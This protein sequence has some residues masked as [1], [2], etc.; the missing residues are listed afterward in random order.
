MYFTS[1]RSNGSVREKSRLTNGLP[2]YSAAVQEKLHRHSRTSSW[3]LPVSVAIPGVH[4]R[5][6]RMLVP[7]PARLHQGSVTRFGRK[8]GTFLLC[9]GL[10]AIIYTMFAI[11]QRYNS[12]QKQWPTPFVGEPS[13]LVFK[14]DDLQ[15]IWKWEIA[16]GHYPS[17]RKSTPSDIHA[18]SISNSSVHTWFFFFFAVPETIGFTSAVPNPALPPRKSSRVPPR[19]RT[20]SGAI[21]TTIGRGPKRVYL[22]MQSSLPRVEYPPRPVPGSIADLDIVMSNCDFSTNQVCLS[23][24][25]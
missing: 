9:I 14:K 23:T 6:L 22:D 8:R 17:S 25:R 7:N 4:E 12:Q 1:H 19:L 2:T 15:S 16:S 3:F 5:K 24:L 13:T 11:N 10:A 21:T 20:L 18:F